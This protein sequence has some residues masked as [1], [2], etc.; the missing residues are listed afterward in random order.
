MLQE[1]ILPVEFILIGRM[2]NILENINNKTQLIINEDCITGMKKLMIIL[3]DII[4]CDH[5]I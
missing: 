5:H 2:L 4:I 1:Y 3:L